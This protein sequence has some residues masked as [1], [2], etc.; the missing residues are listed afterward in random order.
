MGATTQEDLFILD[1]G[2]NRQKIDTINNDGVHTIVVTS[3]P[4]TAGGG[5]G[6]APSTA[7]TTTSQTGAY[8]VTAGALAVMFE[9]VSGTPTVGGQLFPSGVLSVSAPDG[10]LLPTL[11]LVATGGE[12]IVRELRPA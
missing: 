12:V 11:D 8:S 5:S 2:R 3:T 6:S 4:A 7:I 10:F 9:T 1:A